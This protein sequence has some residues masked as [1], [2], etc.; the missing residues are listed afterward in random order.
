MS[1]QNGLPPPSTQVKG[2]YSPYTQGAYSASENK[3]L[4]NKAKY[5]QVAKNIVQNRHILS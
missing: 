1:H 5:T 2:R 3:S 4:K